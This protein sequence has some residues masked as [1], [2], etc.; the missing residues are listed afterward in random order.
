MFKGTLFSKVISG[1]IILAIY[2]ICAPVF[3]AEKDEQF[4]SYEI[5]VV[6]PKYFSKLGRFELGAQGSIIMNN[7]FVYTLMASGILAYHFSEMFAVEGDFA[8]GTSDLLK[9]DEKRILKEEFGIKTQ[10]V[11]VQY[12]G[13]GSI[14]YTPAYGKFQ[15]Y[16][17]K[18][19]YFDTYFAFG[20]G[21]T[22]LDWQY[23]DFCYTK[24][25]Q[26]SDEIKQNKTGNY[27]G[28]ALGFGQR[29]FYSKKSAI[30]WDL[31]YRYI[32]YP[33]G[34][35]SCYVGDEGGSL[36]YTDPVTVQLGASQFF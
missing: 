15:L 34:D 20:G 18:L 22:G 11:R 32:P 1:I 12:L 2:N 16:N 8:Y 17:G 19:I 30:R 10:I 35:A 28:I 6:R 13:E 36:T 31:K 21:M 23:S 5:R 33:S 27:F 26:D 29:I 24:G 3:S 4:E 7:T 14:L 9:R 25:E